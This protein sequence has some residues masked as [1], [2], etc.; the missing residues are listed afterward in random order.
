MVG[1]YPMPGGF[2][3]GR[4]EGEARLEEARLGGSVC[5]SCRRWDWDCHLGDGVFIAKHDFHLLKAVLLCELDCLLRLA[6]IE[7]RPRIDN[8]TV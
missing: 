5:D 8:P 4:H 3:P 6:E 2:S 7:S 1:E